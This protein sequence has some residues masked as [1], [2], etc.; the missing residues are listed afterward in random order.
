MFR[1]CTATLALTTMTTAALI[2]AAASSPVS[3]ASIITE[4]LVNG[5]D[6]IVPSGTSGATNYAY[7]T[8]SNPTGPTVNDLI[9]TTILP[10]NSVNANIAPLTVVD[11][12]SG[13]DPKNLQV[14]T[15]PYDPTSQ[16]I[17]LLFGN[18]GL[19]TGGVINFKLSLDPAY[20]AINAPQLTLTPPDTNLSATGQILS[21]VPNIANG[22]PGEQPPAASQ[23]VSTP[24]PVSLAL[25]SA[26][27]AAGMLR[28]RAFR[29]SRRS[30]D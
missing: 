13:F 10:P 1:R 4:K 21:Y 11:N 17:A 29:K 22:S 8:L 27:A 2:L 9:V 25:W 16:G 5:V 6:Q 28:A 23:S 15:N 26:L 14:L 12:S 3:A 30:A 18:G 20:T 24:E 7:Y 19:A